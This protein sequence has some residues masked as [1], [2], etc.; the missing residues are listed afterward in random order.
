MHTGPYQPE[1]SASELVRVLDQYLADLQAGQALDRA[2]LL[3]AHPDVAA[4]LEKCLAGIEF[5]HQ[6]NQPAPAQAVQL[7]DFRIL[8]EIGRGGMGVVY[9]AEQV[10][11]KRKVALKVLRFGGVADE[12][13]LQRFGREAE[14]VAR[15]HH[16]NIVPIFAVGCEHGVHYYAMQ[17]IEGR[18]LADLLEDHRRR[19]ALP[20]PAEVARW[21][22]QAAEALAHAH[23]RGVI[24]RD[25]KPSNLLLDG[26]GVLWL[27]DFGLARR[28]DELALTLSGIILGTPRYMS[29][30]QAA[31][32]QRLVDHRSDLY[33]LGATVYELAT[34]RPVFDADTPHG[35]ISQILSAEPVAPRQV[36]PE[37]PRDLE[38]I[39]LKCLAKEPDRRYARAEDLAEDLRSFLL[40]RAIKARRPS[41][42]E[43]V[44]RWARRQRRSA[45][46][47]GITAVASVLVVVGSFFA[48][49]AY[50]EWQQGQVLLTTDGPALEAEVLNA[51]DELVMPPFTVPARQPLSL[52]GGLYR[53]RLSAPGQLSETYEM[54]V[55]QGLQ[56]RY[57][58]R[59]AD[60]RL[61]D[62]L[63]VSLGFNVVELDG[64]ADLIVMARDGLRRVNGATGKEVW[65]W[66]TDQ[67]GPL[68][69]PRIKDSE[70]A[71][72]HAIRA[73]VYFK[74]VYNGRAWVAH[75]VPDRQG[76]DTPY[77]VCA[78]RNQPWLLALSAGD[79][80]MK[81]W[82]QSQSPTRGEGG[83]R[84]PGTGKRLH[85][86]PP[87]SVVCP[88]LFA[89]VDGDGVPDVIAVFGSVR[90]DLNDRGEHQEEEP[91]WIEAISGRTGRRL[92]RYTFKHP[93][94]VET[95]APA[96]THSLIVRYAAALSQEEG[97]R[98]LAVAV[99]EEEGESKPKGDHEGRGRL[100]VLDL[101]TG[102]PSRPPTALGFESINTPVF[103]D[104]KGDGHLDVLLVRRKNWGELTVTAI[105]LSGSRL[106][107]HQVKRLANWGTSPIPSITWPVVKDLAGDGKPAIL[108]PYN[109]YREPPQVG[110]VGIEV[111][112]GATGQSRWRRPL[113]RAWGGSGEPGC[114]AHFLPGPDLD[115]DGYREL[116][117]A[118]LIDG[119][120]FDEQARDKKWL[121]AAACSGRDGRVLWQT[122]Q[123][124]ERTN[125]APRLEPLRWGPQGSDGRACLMIG[126][127]GSGPQ[128]VPSVSAIRDNPRQT[129]L[130]SASTGR[131][132]H[133]WPGI[134]QAG[135]AP[136]TGDGLA[137]VFGLS[138]ESQQSPKLHVI[139]ASNELQ[140]VSS[141]KSVRLHVLRGGLPVSGQWLGAWQ[142]SFPGTSGNAPEPICRLAPPLPPGDLNRDGLPDLLVFRGS[143]PDHPD[144][145]ALR[146]YSAKDGHRLWKANGIRGTL[147]Q[148]NV[149]SECFRLECPPQHG[150]GE[151]AVLVAYGVGRFD[152][153]HLDRRRTDSLPRKAGWRCCPVRRV[154]SCGKRSSTGL[155]VN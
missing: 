83:I 32:A 61:W 62:G 1:E 88:P 153:Y 114:M 103:A 50:R 45:V 145:A 27:T 22:L 101:Q 106:W 121:F 102:E 96:S 53:V 77:L 35:I 123:P 48:W 31:A 59:L 75:S 155:T 85:A 66:R 146:A 137:D 37:L 79:G 17:L 81:W 92:W 30:E 117:T 21:G 34:G 84:E 80:A 108:V 90:E 36:R 113:C 149:V 132:E 33:S 10:S 135:T 11:L 116:F 64:R 148:T 29:P 5:I 6:A 95:T 52:P 24:H 2:Q 82:Y 67:P 60:R 120:T 4:Q 134:I 118:A 125:S 110:W 87:G 65:T 42:T 91:R 140:E 143:Q 40:G 74:P 138:T 46:L 8:R 19:Q 128:E 119:R 47:A 15:L 55:E 142:P 133:R 49:H 99:N 70:W 44:V 39:I 139:D 51:N 151:P 41:F 12:A 26:E 23:Q 9:E 16:T 28:A 13:A 126:F 25:V 107:E 130:F 86:P 63:D 98:V 104:L 68:G 78:S 43:R 152:R 144:D 124:V 100:A 115:G 38:T 69:T 112:D 7:G 129:L 20:S 18:S 54:L 136:L 3:A 56:S 71:Y 89:D 131:L 72:L 73:D 58:V 109:N 122:L 111:L 147:R 97:K 150:S 76:V 57:E 127:D 94:A 93:K 141:E 105:D 154:S 14:T